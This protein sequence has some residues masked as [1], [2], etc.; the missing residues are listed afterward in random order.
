MATPKETAEKTGLPPE[1]VT[2]EDG[3]T[4]VEAEATTLNINTTASMRKDKSNADLANEVKR[5]QAHFKGQK[6]V[7]VSIPSVLSA[8]L[9]NILFVGVNGV[10]INVPVDGEDHDVPE[11]FALHIKQILKDLK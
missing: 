7:K 3:V 8:K 11:V 6:K 2:T 10:S 9:G 1:R 5:A 4:G